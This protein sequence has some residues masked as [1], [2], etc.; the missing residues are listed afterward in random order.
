MSEKIRLQK[1]MAECG[2]ASRRACET[3][4]TDGRVT[5]NGLKAQELGTKIDPDYDEICVDGKLIKKS[6]KNII[7]CLI[8]PQAILP[9]QATNLGEKLCLI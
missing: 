8:N 1:Y 4:I 5:V 2:V 6:K 9:R 7:L 3:I